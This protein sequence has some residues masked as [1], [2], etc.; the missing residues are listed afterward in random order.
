MGSALE[1][2][3]ATE[4]P[5]ESK[6]QERTWI[7]G[8]RGP[9]GRDGKIQTLWK[10]PSRVFLTTRLQLIRLDAEVLH[11]LKRLQWQG[12]IRMGFAGK[13]AQ[14]YPISARFCAGR[15]CI[16]SFQSLAI[17]TLYLRSNQDEA[18]NGKSNI[19][20]ACFDAP[21]VPQHWGTVISSRDDCLYNVFVWIILDLPST[22]VPD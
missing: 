17:W 3:T 4:A 8:W 10:N 11:T 13:C 16:L 9:R 1:M 22:D 12:S 21:A 20:S 19:S 5:L 6:P 7:P 14:W 18:W 2:K 15:G